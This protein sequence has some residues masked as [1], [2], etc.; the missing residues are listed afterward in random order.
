LK[1]NQISRIV[2]AN[3]WEDQMSRRTLIV[4]AAALASGCQTVGSGPP[5][6]DEAMQLASA[7]PA[8]YRDEIVK[9]LRTLLKDPY[10][11]RSAEI[12][13]PAMGFVGI[14]NGGN[15]PVVC[16]RYNAK[17]SFGAYIG[18]QATAFIFRNGSVAGVIEDSPLACERR[19]Y[20]P[21]P[22]LE[23]IT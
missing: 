19:Q 3:Y 21:F 14:V 9:R 18:V 13:S 10:S 23:K 15:A 8:N 11:V 7:V 5:A 22:E 4:L 6:A 2:M 12:S 16:A 20:S 17:N 1:K